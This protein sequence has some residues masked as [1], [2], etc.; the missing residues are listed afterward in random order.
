MH[1][2]A[3]PFFRSNVFVPSLPPQTAPLVIIYIYI[4]MYVYI[5]IYIYMDVHEHKHVTEHTD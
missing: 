3:F 5:Y 2:F 4:Y 1:G